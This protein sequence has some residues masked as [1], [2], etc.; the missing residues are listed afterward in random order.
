MNRPLTVWVI[1]GLS[2]AVL[3]AAM[4]WVSLTTLRLDQA[5]TRAAQQAELEEKVRLA[6]WRM[7]SSL[8]PMIV[9]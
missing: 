3:L 9:E 6:L 5:Q 1:F 7:D 8:A 2:F 4:G